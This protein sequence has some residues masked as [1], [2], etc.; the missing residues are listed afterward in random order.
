MQQEGRLIR[1]T[2]GIDD[3]ELLVLF[4]QVATVGNSAHQQ[5]YD[6]KRQARQH[7]GSDKCNPARHDLRFGVERKQAVVLIRRTHGIPG[8]SLIF[9]AR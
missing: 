7:A 6:P 2:D 4:G 8:S 1:R 5:H 3:A 9:D